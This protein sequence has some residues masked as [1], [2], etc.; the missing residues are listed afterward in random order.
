[1]S[2][3]RSSAYNLVGALS[4]LGYLTKRRD[5]I[6]T[7]TEQSRAALEPTGRG[8]LRSL[9]AVSWALQIL[10]LLGRGPS[11][12]AALSRATGVDEETVSLLLQ[13]LR[14]LG[15]AEPDGANGASYRLGPCVFELRGPAQEGILP[16]VALPALRDLATKTRETVKLAVASGG[17]ALVVYAIES[18]RVLR[19]RSDFSA[20]GLLHGSAVGKALLAFLPEDEARRA[21]RAPLQRLTPK[22]I[23]RPQALQAE[24][25]RVRRRGWSFDDEETDP[26]VRCVGAP[27]LTPDGFAAGSISVSGPVIR[28]TD[29]VIPRLP[30][31]WWRRRG[32]SAVD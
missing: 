7:L 3:P 19:A 9:E 14:I 26:G 4:T 22:T 23:I 31:S 29:S 30:G 6:L 25:Q 13:V 20:V 12:P 17:R 28:L 11:S 1:M 15:F 24:L 18:P 27:I 21:L 32:R 5:G 16:D 2:I 8:A 10:S